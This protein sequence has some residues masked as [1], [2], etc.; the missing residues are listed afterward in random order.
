[1]MPDNDETRA[2][3]AGAAEDASA[4][5]VGSTLAGRYHLEKLLGVGAMG[6]VYLGRHL[7]IGRRDAIKVLHAETARDPAAIARF[8][9]GA[10]NI[11]AIRHPNVCTIH[12]FGDTD[13]GLRYLAMEYVAG[14]ALKDLL[15][16]EGRLPVDRAL[17]IIEQVAAGLQAAHD[18]G[19]VHRDLKPGNIMIAPG[20]AGEDLVKVVDFDISKGSADGLEAEVTRLGYVI[21]TPEYMSPEQLWGGALDGRS[22]VYS[23]AVVLYRMLT[24]KLPFSGATVQE[25]LSERLADTP[26][27]RLNDCATDASF[28]DGLQEVLDRALKPNAAD[29]T[30]SAA[31]F[32]A[33]LRRTG[34]GAGTTDLPA[35]RVARAAQPTGAALAGGGAAARPGLRRTMLAAAVVAVL[36]ASG[37]AASQTGIF[38]GPARDTAASVDLPALPVARA[39]DEPSGT[40]GTSVNLG[41]GSESAVPDPPPP[42]ERRSGG[43]RDQ[44]AGPPASGEPEP[45]AGHPTESGA[46]VTIA[47]A[48]TLAEARAFVDAQR[49][50]LGS[51]RPTDAASSLRALRD[52]ASSIHQLAGLPDMQR[53][54]AAGIAAS[55][56]L[57]LQDY[58]ACVRWATTAASLGTRAYAAI[59]E[60]CRAGGV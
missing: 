59:L 39:G 51:G 14:A 37:F 15:D 11:G 40:P 33:Q 22:D 30:A 54:H 26:L 45:P 55:M 41:A 32:S 58:A 34:G 27:L 20:P 42:A 52:T 1:M 8:D 10:R 23:M 21:G 49:L 13:E 47:G 24:G 6:A 4:P 19:V 7:K 2:F 53:A 35:T 36:A 56:S 3:Q 17:R 38:A 43:Q 25:M 28:P 18:A 50:A 31:E 9:R 46:P 12:D 60:Q 29:R 5:L 57:Y 48:M 44:T 16:R